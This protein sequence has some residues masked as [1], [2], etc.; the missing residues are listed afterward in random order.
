MEETKERRFSGTLSG[1]ILDSV[2][3]FN[4]AAMPTYL[5]LLALWLLIPTPPL[6]LHRTERVPGNEGCKRKESTLI[7]T[8]DSQGGRRWLDSLVLHVQMCPPTAEG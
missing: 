2:V 3:T 6:T 4:S 1:A 5:G 8:D 7:I